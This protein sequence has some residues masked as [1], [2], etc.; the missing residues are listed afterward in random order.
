MSCF[1]G[2]DLN[3]LFDSESEYGQNYLFDDLTDELVIRAEETMGYKLPESYKELL[4]F[5]NGG[6]I[7]SELDESWLA[8]I[9]GISADPDN[10]YGLESMYDNWKNEW[11]Y[12]DIGIPFGE[13]ESAGHDM[14]YMD[15]RVTD[16]NG[17]QRIVRIDNEMENEV[18]V[19]A[20]NLP[21]FIR[22]VLKNEPIDETLLDED[23]LP[24]SAEPEQPAEEK[25][26]SFFGK[27]FKS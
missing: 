9:Y 20:D 2:I 25:K 11:E 14:Y 6:S 23:G 18:F 10:F 8:A 26:T 12:P 17:E 19:V 22:M 3:R 13:T 21:E 5:R 1:E 27:L 15:F 16:E 24:V 7:S 4:R